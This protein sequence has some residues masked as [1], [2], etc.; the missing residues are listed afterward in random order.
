MLIPLLRPDAAPD[1]GH[2]PQD[3]EDLADALRLSRP[4]DGVA[5]GEDGPDEP[6]GGGVVPRQ[7]QGPGPQAVRDQ[8]QLRGQAVFPGVSRLRCRKRARC[9]I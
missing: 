7:A 3:V 8:I 5:A 4:G 9:R 2:G 6:G 1:L